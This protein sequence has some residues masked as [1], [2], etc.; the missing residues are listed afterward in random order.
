MVNGASTLDVMRE[1]KSL[2]LELAVDDFG[3][4]HT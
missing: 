3:A 1:L 2:G 4:G